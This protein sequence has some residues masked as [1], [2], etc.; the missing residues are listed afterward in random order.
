MNQPITNI[1]FEDGVAS[2]D[3]C[4]GNTPSAITDTRE[5][6]AASLTG[7]PVTIYDAKGRKIKETEHF[8]GLSGL[9]QGI[10]ILKGQNFEQKTVHHE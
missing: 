6:L 9:P 7:Q 2:F 3:F 5:D 1:T 10:Y 8:N 4:G